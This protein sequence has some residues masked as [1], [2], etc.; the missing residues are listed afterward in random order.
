MLSSFHQMKENFQLHRKGVYRFRSKNSFQLEFG[1][2]LLK[3]AETPTELIES[4]KLRHQVFNVEFRGLSG[5]GLDYDQY[6]KIF[7]HLLIIQKDTGAVVGTYRVHCSW[8]PHNSYTALE[9]DLTGLEEFQ[10]PY[11]ELGRAC[12]H[13]DHRR[14]AVISLL[15]RGIAEYMKMSGAQTLFGCSSLK[16][17]DSRKAALIYR[18]LQN[19]NAV[20]E[21]ICHPTDEYSF[22]DISGWM[23][24][25]QKPLATYHHEEAEDL[26]PSLLKSYLKL[27]AKIAAW[28]AFDRDFDC[29]DFLTVLKRSE[30]SAS[31][32]RKFAVNSRSG[33]A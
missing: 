3:T 14:G 30:L 20:L 16:V 11:L 12:I 27:G 6:D 33:R 19:Q 8:S 29:L 2:Y 31:I 22:D 13:Q 18:H 32:D 5:R 9:F 1:P 4:F 21:N 28:P 10:G 25:F 26:I 17:N 24:H 23:N 15:W 7:D